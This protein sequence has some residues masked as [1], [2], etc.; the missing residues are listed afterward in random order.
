MKLHFSDIPEDGVRIDFHGGSARWDG[1]KDFSVDRAPEGRFF[2][3]RRGRDVF[4][5]GVVRATVILEC[6]RCLEAFPLALEASVSQILHPEEER[7]VEAKEIELA[8]DDLEFAAY[9]G[10]NIPLEG[11]AEEHLLLSLPMRPLCR[12]EC[13]G[14]CVGCGENLNLGTCRC[15]DGLGKSPF[16]SLKQFVVKER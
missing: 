15:P 9:D 12:E 11:V 16:D 13:R 5:E 10:E 14:L 8:R 3:R 1:L 4:I 6:S 2:V 7:R